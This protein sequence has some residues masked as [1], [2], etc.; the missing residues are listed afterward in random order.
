MLRRLCCILIE[1][2]CKL[3]LHSRLHFAYKAIGNVTETILK[4]MLTLN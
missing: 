1:V 4:V 3:F 2:A